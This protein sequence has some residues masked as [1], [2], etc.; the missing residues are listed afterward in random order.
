[1]KYDRHKNW[2][3]AERHKG[4]LNYTSERLKTFHQKS[5]CLPCLGNSEMVSILFLLRNL[6]FEMKGL[7]YP[8]EVI[9]IA[10]RKV[11]SSDI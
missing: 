11:H 8:F 6:L 9:F 4:K 3:Y 7:F 1:M 5:F 10:T 2:M